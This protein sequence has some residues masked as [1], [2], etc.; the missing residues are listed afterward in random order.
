ML[1]F[2]RRDAL[3]KAGSLAAAALG[4]DRA[5]SAFAADSGGPTGVASGAVSCVLTPELTEGPF[6]VVGEKLRRDITEGKQGVPLRLELSVVDASTCKAIRNAIVDI[7]HADSAGMYS[8]VQGNAGTFLRGLQRTNAHGLATFETIYPGWYQG[9]ATHI[10]VK[11]HLGGNVVH[12][13]QLF[14]ADA[15]NTAVYK[16]APYNARGAGAMRNA[17]DAIF[18]N[19]GS[20][21]MLHIR[22]SGNGYVASIAMGVTRG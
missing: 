1:D 4:L 2:T 16:R 8:G 6:Y 21:S 18:R 15:L 14:F 9:R 5:G 3:L 7:W 20:K 17:E 10:H 13:G 19:G 22:K 11:V 12:T